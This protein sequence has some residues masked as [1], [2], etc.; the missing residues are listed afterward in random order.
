[1]AGNTSG[2][3]ELKKELLQPGLILAD[4]GI[5]LAVRALKI[6][7]AHDGRAAV[8]GTGDV[9]HVCPGPET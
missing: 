2:K 9:D 1:V 6:R 3:R 4:L 8:P 7:I 5:D